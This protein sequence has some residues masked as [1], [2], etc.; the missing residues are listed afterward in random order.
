MSC[1]FSDTHS[2]L[3]LHLPSIVKSTCWVRLS[4]AIVRYIHPGS[5]LVVSNILF[6]DL[7]SG[8]PFSVLH[9]ALTLTP[10]DSSLDSWS[11]SHSYMFQTI[12]RKCLVYLSTFVFACLNYF[13]AFLSYRPCYWVALPPTSS[14]LYRHFYV[15][16]DRGPHPRMRPAWH[17]LFH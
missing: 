8:L 14:Y 17:F 13:L 7:V 3:H 1:C 16:V 2:S 4:V 15:H 6:G 11:C 10:L 12:W 9:S 5:F